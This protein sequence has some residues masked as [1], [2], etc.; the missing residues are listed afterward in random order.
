MERNY[1]ILIYDS[2]Q[3]IRSSTSTSSPGLYP[4]EIV[5]QST[6]EVMMEEQTTARVTDKEGEDRYSLETDWSGPST[7]SSFT[8][9]HSSNACLHSSSSRDMM[10]SLPTDSLS[11]TAKPALIEPKIAGVPPSSRISGFSLY[12]C[13]LLMTYTKN[14]IHMQTVYPLLLLISTHLD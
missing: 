3:S 8:D 10:N 5:Q 6:D 9:F 11:W 13:L 7:T 1:N 4:K 14:Y 12:L 2:Y